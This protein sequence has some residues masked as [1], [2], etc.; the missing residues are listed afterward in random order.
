MDLDT[1]LEV[2]SFFNTCNGVCLR[3]LHHDL[4]QTLSLRSKLNHVVG[5]VI[6]HEEVRNMEVTRNK[7][8]VGV[9]FVKERRVVGD[10]ALL[11]EN[12]VHVIPQ[13]VG[14][15][16]YL[17]APSL[18]VVAK[19]VTVRGFALLLVNTVRILHVLVF[20]LLTE[21]AGMQIVAG[22]TFETTAVPAKAVA[23]LP[24]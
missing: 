18:L 24:L 13:V 17:A 3:L 20:A 8:L 4:E 21:E 9:N 7:L 16:V 11:V 23:V 10:R 6:R 12:V 22:A 5:V 15:I 14:D 2:H 19:H 1:D